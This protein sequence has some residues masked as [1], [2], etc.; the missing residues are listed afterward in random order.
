MIFYNL[1]EIVDGNLKMT[2][3]MI[4]TIILR[5]AIQDIAIEG[6]LFYAE[7]NSLSFSK[8]HNLGRWN[9]NMRLYFCTDMFAKDGLLLWCQRKTA[10]YKNVKVQNF[11]TRS[12]WI[13][14]QNHGN[15]VQIYEL[16]NTFCSFQFQ[17]WSCILRFDPSPQTRSYQ[18][19]CS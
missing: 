11:H 15:S 4:W 7:R 8:L 6:K 10:P 14:T 13:L 17:G 12:V 9:W 16:V 1:L 2:L 5:F 19:W 18:L 3:G